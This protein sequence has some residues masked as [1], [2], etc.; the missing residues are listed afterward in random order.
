MILLDAPVFVRWAGRDP[1]F[2]LERQGL[3]DART[4]GIALCQS[5]LLE[6]A[7]AHR[8]GVWSSQTPLQIWLETA[9]TSRQVVLLPPTPAIV[10]RSARFTV[11]DVWD[12]LFLATAIEHDLEVATLDPVL[13]QS[14]GIRHLF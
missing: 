13:R 14:L 3:L 2:G 9:L 5:A 4:D 6:I 11:G 12:R 10:S 8:E 1:G 7:E